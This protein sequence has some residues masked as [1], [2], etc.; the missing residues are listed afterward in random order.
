M[1]LYNTP[2][3]KSLEENGIEY[4]CKDIPEFSL[5]EYRGES[6]EDMVPDTLD[7]QERALLAINGIT[8]PTDVDKDYEVY[9]IVSFRRNPP[10]MTHRI[11]DH[12]QFKFFEGVPLLRTI[13]GSDHNIHVD[14]R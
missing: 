2:I 3:G 13:T 10:S 14:R 4:I 7:I 12:V 9:W 11:H 6:Y 1:K 8:A 5:P